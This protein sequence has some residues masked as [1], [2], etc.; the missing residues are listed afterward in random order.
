MATSAKSLSLRF[1]PGIIATISISSACIAGGS[2][3]FWSNS[4]GGAFNDPLNWLPEVVPGILDIAFY[5]ADEI[6]AVSVSQNSTN[7]ALVLDG[8]ITTFNHS[9]FTYTV[10]DLFIAEHI[11]EVGQLTVVDGQLISTSNGFTRIGKNF[12]SDGEL[13]VTST[14]IVSTFDDLLIGDAGVG[15]LTIQPGGSVSSETA[16][17]GDDAGSV[18][19]ANVTGPTAQWNLSGDLTI[20]NNGIGDLAISNSGSVTV[21]GLTK[22]GDLVGANGSITVTGAGSNLTTSGG[23]S[24][25]NDKIGTL[26]ISNGGSAEHHIGLTRIGNNI[27]SNGSVSVDGSGS[28]WICSTELFIGNFSFGSLSIDNGANVFTSRV[29]VGDEIGSVGVVNING[30]SLWIDT[31]EIFVGNFGT[32]T[33]TVSGSAQVFANLTT[34]GDDPGS[35]GE[36]IVKGAGS[37]WTSSSTFTNGNLGSGLLEVSNNGQVQVG[38][39]IQNAAGTLDI[40]IGSGY[41]TS[42]SSSGNAQLTGSLTVSLAAGYSPKPGEQ[43]TILNANS[44]SGTFPQIDAPANLEVSYESNAVIVTVTDA[45]VC[46]ADLDDNGTVGTGDLLILFSQWGTDGPAD[47]D[48][49][50]SVG[51]GDL[52]ILFANWGPCK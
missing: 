22:V 16:V 46:P 13:I 44:R 36:I 6:Y 15:A 30:N 51:T 1:L 11:T 14:G 49:N 40:Q 20:A 27:G 42:V 4:S 29:K 25:G 50:G 39:Y 24:L 31:V 9:G 3:I 7:S 17:L 45:P 52:L 18:G 2:D 35:D 48:G 37:T 47:L 21:Q 5:D 10:G 34:I 43:F 33:A 19:S 38:S 28:T 12:G 32:G 23:F 26:V 8:D 41:I